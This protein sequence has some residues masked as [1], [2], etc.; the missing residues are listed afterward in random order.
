[1]KQFKALLPVVAGGLMLALAACGGPVTGPEPSD[2]APATTAPET[3]AASAGWDINETPREQLAEGGE[4]IGSYSSPIG[5]WNTRSALGND[6]ELVLLEAPISPAYYDYN[7]VGDAILNP[8]YLISAETTVGPNLVVTL[9]LNPNAVW[10]D[11]EVIGADDWIATWQALNGSNQEFGAASSDGWDRIQSVEAGATEQDVI[12]TFESTYPDWTAI[13]ADGPLRAESVATP[14]D[15]NDGWAEY[16]DEYFTGPFRVSS[17]DKTSG[18]VVMERNP[19][20]WGATPLLDRITWKLIKQDALAAAFA[21]QEVDYLDIGA[22]PDAYQQ[23]LNAQNAVVRVAASPDYRN[24]TFNTEAGFLTDVDVRQAIMMGL[25]RTIIAQSDLAG[26][27]GDVAPLNNNLFVM[28]QTGFVDQAAATGI[29]YDPAGAKQKLEGAGWVLNETS[30]FYEKD[31]EQL[32]VEFAVLPDT[33][34]SVNEGLQAQNMLKQIGVNLTLRN[35]DVQNEWPSVLIEHKFEIIGFSWYGT[36][37]PLRSIGQVYGGSVDPAT[38]EWTASGNNFAQLRID[39][40]E[41]LRPLI[42]TEMDPV[43]RL[44]LGN[45]V[46]Q[47]IWEAGHTLPLYQRPMLIGVREGSAN[48]GALGMARVPKWENVGFVK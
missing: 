16:V 36:A 21:N 39:V 24:F 18:T 22:D 35:I 1:M 47:A 20:W 45:Q 27:P 41:E 44:E 14:S 33:K 42:D 26:L 4:W 11:G 30:G 12:I 10:N 38:G 29:D 6:L 9:K 19:N 15:F 8:D 48:I 7:G 40:V 32:D 23:A 28:G 31:G 25:D 46:A 2:G 5:T 34:E 13:V 43:K 3:P 37:Y 17:H